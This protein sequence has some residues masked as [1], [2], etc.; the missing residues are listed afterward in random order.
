MQLTL[1]LISY[2]RKVLVY[3]WLEFHNN[4]LKLVWGSLI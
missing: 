1:L 4:I 3:T 2:L